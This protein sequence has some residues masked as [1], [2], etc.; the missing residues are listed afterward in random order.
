[1]LLLKACA[2]LELRNVVTRSA[3]HLVYR[4]FTRIG[5]EKVS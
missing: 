3:R 1:M 2:R 4:E 5:G